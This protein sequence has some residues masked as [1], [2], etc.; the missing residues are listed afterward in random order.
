MGGS[1]KVRAVRRSPSSGRT[2]ASGSATDAAA[3][4]RT[5]GRRPGGRGGRRPVCR[6]ADARSGGGPAADE[7]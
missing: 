1:A 6:V 2:R 7:L 4:G 5:A 3:C